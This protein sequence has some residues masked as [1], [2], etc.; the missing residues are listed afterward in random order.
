[1]SIRSSFD[2]GMT[3]EPFAIGRILALLWAIGSMV[4]Q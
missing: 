3:A 4:V 2:A 1:M